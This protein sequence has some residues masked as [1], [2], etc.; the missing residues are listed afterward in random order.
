MSSPAASVHSDATLA[1]AA[2]I[3]VRMDLGADE[4]A[5]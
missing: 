3:T 1:E 4:D 5:A 2:R